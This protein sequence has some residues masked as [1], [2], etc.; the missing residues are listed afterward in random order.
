[1]KNKLS[2]IRLILVIMSLFLYPSCGEDFLQVKPLGEINAQNFFQEEKHGGWA[3]NAIYN[4]LRSWDMVSFP[5]LGMTD[6]VSDD[7]VKGS[8]PADAERLNAFDDFTY[9]SRTPEDIRQTWKGYYQAIFRANVAIE[10]IPKIPKMNENLR[11]KWLGEAHFLRAYFYFNLVRWFGQ[12]PLITKPLTQ[13]EFYTQQRAAVEKVYDLIKSDLNLAISSLPLKSALDAADLGRVTKGAAAGL[14][15]KVFLTQRDFSNAS[16]WAKEVIDSKEYSLF[17]DYARLFRK[18]GENGVESLFEIQATA[19]EAS[20]AGA[21]PF[22]MVQGVRGSPNL[23]W[24]FNNPS[25]DLVRSYEPGD[26]RRDA[27]VLYVG[28]V[29]PDGSGVIEDNPSMENERYNQKAW[30]ESHPGLQDNGPGN[31]RILRYADVL[32]IAAEALN[33][34]NNPSEALKYLNQVRQRAR[35]T[36]TTV[37]P[38]VV[39]TDKLTLRERIWKERRIELAMEQQRWFD[40]VRTDQAEKVMKN[41]GKNFIK[42]KHDLFPIPQTEI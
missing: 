37:L 6:I 11:K 13:E 34:L 1:M 36:R 2:S 17:P 31:I 4:Q 10:G 21:T 39:F 40:L 12:V 22:N 9:D 33:E 25:D 28:E 24:G 7:A 38:D 5:Y 20:W 41:V 3:V 23:G 27:T 15:A 26:P 14:M 19:L 32:L 16:K 8:F 30:V 18:E 42:G 35:G 29:L